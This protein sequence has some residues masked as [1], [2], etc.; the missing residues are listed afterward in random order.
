LNKKVAM[1]LLA[2]VMEEA[3][4]KDGKVM[5][6]ITGTSMLP[7]LRHGKDRICLVKPGE[8]PL[9]KYDIPLFVRDDGKYILHRIVRV[10]PLG[11]GVTGDNQCVIEYPVRHDQVIGVVQGIYRGDKYISCDDISYRVYSGL[12]VL[13]RPFRCLFMKGKRLIMR[14][15]GFCKKV[16]SSMKEK[17]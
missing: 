10:T 8:K 7:L 12:W 17:E 6:T 1:S 15:V 2:P 3:L 13:I 4:Q 5:L 9:K 14:T 11:Y 16:C